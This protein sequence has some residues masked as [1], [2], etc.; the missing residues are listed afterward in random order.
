MGTVKV[1]HKNTPP[2]CNGTYAAASA[3]EGKSRISVKAVGVGKPHLMC[4]NR[5]H[6]VL[7]AVGR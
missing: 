6:N 3:S 2:L 1:D 7:S 4:V 5:N